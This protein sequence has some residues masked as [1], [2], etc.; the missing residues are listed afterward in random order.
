MKKPEKERETERETD[1]ERQTER[2]RSEDDSNTVHAV[3]DPHF[4]SNNVFI[5]QMLLSKATQFHPTKT[6]RV[7]VCGGGGGG[8]GRLKLPL[9]PPVPPLTVHGVLG[10][11]EELG[12]R[13]EGVFLVE[14]HEQDGRDLTHALAV[15]HFLWGSKAAERRTGLLLVLL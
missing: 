5:L 2:H 4:T 14:V 13:P 8:F 9:F 10:V 1:R 11:G 3:S 7:Y 6:R 12:Q 15:A